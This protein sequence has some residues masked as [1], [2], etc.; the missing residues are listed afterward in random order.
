MFLI[1]IGL[2]ISSLSFYC[3]FYGLEIISLDLQI[4]GSGLGIGAFLFGIL[5]LR[6]KNVKAKAAPTRRTNVHLT[7]TPL[8]EIY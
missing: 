7:N 1:T 3:L 8:K 6:F 5:S 2:A 4:V